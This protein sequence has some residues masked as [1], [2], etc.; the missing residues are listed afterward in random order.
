LSLRK[1]EDVFAAQLEVGGP[2]RDDPT[3]RRVNG[4]SRR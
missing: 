3:V 4:S 2:L 1:V